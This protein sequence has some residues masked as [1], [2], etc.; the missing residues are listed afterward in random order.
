MGRWPHGRRC[1]QTQ[2]SSRTRPK[3][4][5][6]WHSH[7]SVPNTG[8]MLTIVKHTLLWPAQL[9]SRHWRIHM[10]WSILD[11]RCASLHSS[12]GCHVHPISTSVCLAGGLPELTNPCQCVTLASL[13]PSSWIYFLLREAGNVHARFAWQHLQRWCVAARVELMG[14]F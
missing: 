13:D 9:D 12:M 8:Q 2:T 10:V 7:N 1:C 5:G 4:P 14:P 6:V 11:L 3:Q